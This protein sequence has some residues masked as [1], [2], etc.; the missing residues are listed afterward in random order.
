MIK[1]QKKLGY[2]IFFASQFLSIGKENFNQSQNLFEASCFA[3]KIF[4]NVS[5][6]LNENSRNF[7]LTKLFFKF[8]ALSKN[9]FPL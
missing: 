9:K 5:K 8:L 6:N 1:L 7:R 2:K 4:S 3:H